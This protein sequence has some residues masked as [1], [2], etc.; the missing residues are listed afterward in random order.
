RTDRAFDRIGDIELGFRFVSARAEEF[1]KSFLE[2]I[3]NGV[4]KTPAIHRNQRLPVQAALA[5]V[6]RGHRRAIALANVGYFA[7][8]REKTVLG[9]VENAARDAAM[10]GQRLLEAIP[11]EC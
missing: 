4:M 5:P 2:M 1:Q 3:E 9:D 7:D 6:L 11:D 10:V 8:P